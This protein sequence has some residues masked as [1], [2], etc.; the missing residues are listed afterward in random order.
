MRRSTAAIL[1]GEVLLF[2]SPGLLEYTA[3]AWCTGAAAVRFY[4]EP[5]RAL[6]A[7]PPRPHR[8]HRTGPLLHLT[9][10]VDA[11]E[12]FPEVTASGVYRSTFSTKLKIG[13]RT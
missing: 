1:A 7:H 10:P 5:T 4:E 2:A 12:G 8:G 11:V 9:R 13:L 3:V 6:A